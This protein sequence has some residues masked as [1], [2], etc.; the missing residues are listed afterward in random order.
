MLLAGETYNFTVVLNGHAISPKGKIVYL[1]N[2]PEFTYG[3]G[4]SFVQLSED[5]E[6]HLNGFLSTRES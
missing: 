5:H 6:S 1:E 4:I 3:A 2:Q